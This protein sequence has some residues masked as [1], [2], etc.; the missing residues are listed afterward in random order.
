MHSYLTWKR[1]DKV[2]V[3]PSSFVNLRCPALLEQQ[4]KSFLGKS[5]SW[6]IINI[7]LMTLFRSSLPEVFY[8]K[9]GLKNFTKFTGNYLCQAEAC[10]LI[11]K[12]TLSQVFSLEFCK[13]FK[14]IFSCRTPPVDC[15]LFLPTSNT[16]ST[17]VDCLYCWD[18]F[19]NRGDMVFHRLF[20]VWYLL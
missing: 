4:F 11:K 10:N 15:F 1:I 20:P 2:C 17:S 13:I 6:N 16:F 9:S 8:K 3:W 18:V 12:E 14:N 19:V 5:W 7:I